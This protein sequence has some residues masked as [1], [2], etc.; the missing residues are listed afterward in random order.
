M[1]KAVAGKSKAATDM[2]VEELTKFIK[3][4]GYSTVELRC[5]GELVTVGLQVRVQEA[6]APMRTILSTGK[7]QRLSINGWS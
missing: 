7:T 1:M 6:R 4:L 3:Q 5:D 2:M